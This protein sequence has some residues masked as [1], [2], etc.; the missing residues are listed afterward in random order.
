MR[1]QIFKNTYRVLKMINAVAET[2]ILDNR[3]FDIPDRKHT[4]KK[5]KKLKKK[6]IFE[7]VRLNTLFRKPVFW[8]LV[9]THFR[10]YRIFKNVC[11]ST[12]Q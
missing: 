3:V 7:N 9:D 8:T 1:N 6:K 5:K 11:H 12:L 4:F 10:K 2:R